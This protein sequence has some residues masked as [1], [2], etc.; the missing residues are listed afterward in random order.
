LAEPIEWRFV[1]HV[2]GLHLA[3]TRVQCFKLKE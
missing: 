3:A 1:V 2:D